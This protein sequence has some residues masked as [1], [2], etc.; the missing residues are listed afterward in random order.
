M[1]KKSTRMINKKTTQIK[2]AT[3]IYLV[4]HLN[5]W[6]YGDHKT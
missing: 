2:M 1:S 3:N 5:E 4:N 6:V